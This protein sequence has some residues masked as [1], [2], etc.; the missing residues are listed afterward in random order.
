MNRRLCWISLNPA[1][2][3]RTCTME[4]ESCNSM[5]GCVSL[6][7]T[8]LVCSCRTRGIQFYDTGANPYQT[9]AESGVLSLVHLCL[10]ACLC[11]INTHYTATPRCVRVHYCMLT[12]LGVAVDR[13][14]SAHWTA[15]RC[16][17]VIRYLTWE[18]MRRRGVN[19][20]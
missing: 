2:R 14:I 17:S 18:V 10:S 6:M 16:S 4:L 15:I 19:L 13:Y 12:S 3:H 8:H 20:R 7:W 1:N 11:H 9:A 5:F